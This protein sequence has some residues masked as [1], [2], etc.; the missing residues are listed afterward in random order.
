[1]IESHQERWHRINNLLTETIGTVDGT[2]AAV[3]RVVAA[4]GR[5]KGVDRTYALR[6]L[7]TR[8]MSCQHYHSPIRGGDET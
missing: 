8:S 7:A 4:V 2:T 3:D 1:M 5:M 6:N